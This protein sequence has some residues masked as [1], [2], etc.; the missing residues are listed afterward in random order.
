MKTYII[1]FLISVITVLAP[2]QESVLAIGFLIF[3]DLIMGL[4]SSYRKNIPITSKRLKNTGVKLLVY[5]L[6]LISG[7]VAEN[8]LVN[9]IPFI[10]ISLTFLCLVEIKS[11]G[12]NFTSI[13]GLP[14]TK[15]L[16]DKIN[17][18]LNTENK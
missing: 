11:I 7:F 15:Y 1:N 9:W 13:T 14:F 6:L 12:E 8:Y 10:K 4:I 3:T 16:K 17:N 5:N 2:L 18:Y